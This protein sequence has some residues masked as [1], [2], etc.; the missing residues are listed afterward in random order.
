MRLG[1]AMGRGEGSLFMRLLQMFMMTVKDSTD[2]FVPWPFSRFAKLAMNVAFCRGRK[3][4]RWLSTQRGCG[5]A[6][7]FHRA[8]LPFL[9]FVEL[10]R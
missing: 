3:L 6:S 2:F 7:G 5:K 1:L 10:F 9:F 8:R 4:S